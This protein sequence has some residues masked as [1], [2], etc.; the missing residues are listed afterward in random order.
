MQLVELQLLASTSIAP[1]RA[2]AMILAVGLGVITIG[3]GILV[4]TRWGQ[5][6]PLAKCAGLSLFAHLLLLCYCYGTRVFFESPGR[7]TAD[8]TINVRIED[9]TDEVEAG[10]ESIAD[11]KELPKVS[12]SED[13]F[14]P[15]KE[16]PK[17]EPAPPLVPVV[18]KVAE[19]PPKPI[20]KPKEAVAQAKP[21]MP[22]APAIEPTPLEEPVESPEETTLVAKKPMPRETAIDVAASEVL[23][24]PAPQESSDAEP[25]PIPSIASIP[26]ESLP[27]S[28]PAIPRRAGDG[29]EM[30]AMLRSR[31]SDRLKI[32]QRHG[33]TVT[34]E[35]AVNAALDWMAASQSAD[36]RWDADAHGAG[37]EAKIMGHD[38]G[39]AGKKADTGITGLALLAFLGAGESHLEGKHR[40]NVQHGL[41]FLLD[42]QAA[43]DSLAGDAELFAAMYCHGIATLALSEAYAMTG[44]E[45][46]KNAA[47]KAI[48]YT[49]RSQHSGGGWR[50]RPGDAGDLSQFGWQVMSLKSAEMAGLP[51]PAETRT[52]MGR[53]LRSCSSGEHG[54][55]ASYR[56]GDRTSRTMTAEALCCR[57]FLAAEDSPA[58]QSEA[59]TFVMEEVP[60]RESVNLY[61]WYYGTVAM[62]QRQGEDWD[63]WNAAMQRELLARQRHDGKLV[64]SWDPDNLWGNYGGR[65][66]S[67]A[68]ATLCLEVY[69]RYLPLYGGDDPDNPTR[70]TERADAPERSR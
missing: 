28:A 7:A 62:F 26:P 61:Y 59:A 45:R 64:G 38:R 29:K 23:P 55:L 69:Y 66:Y 56:P 3:L 22:P 65:V 41:E 20:D 37:K 1:A 52:R 2:L 70:L 6:R 54:G 27:I 42:S 32:A 44:D 14:F 11:T 46:L 57:I 60:I 9:V 12:S 31:V 25:L 67:T 17:R 68:M 5:A 8:G 63:R 40:E 58:A 53:F 33:G 4:W 21:P 16:T 49:I 48:N 13:V 47:T 51:I 18:V 15:A 30:P 24:S 36:G 19:A 35:A 43:D 50:Y 10:P 39:G 34:S